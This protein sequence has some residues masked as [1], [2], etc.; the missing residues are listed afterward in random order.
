MQEV[1]FE[2]GCDGGFSGGRE[3][4]EPDCEAALF[5]ELVALVAGEGGVPGYIPRGE[6]DLR[7]MAG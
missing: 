6:L 2:R 5:A 7:G 3:T 4:G 1:L